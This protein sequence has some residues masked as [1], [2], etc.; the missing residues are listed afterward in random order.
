[1]EDEAEFNK[2]P[3]DDRCVHKVNCSIQKIIGG[4]IVKEARRMVTGP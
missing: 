3:L 2:I 4:V 1:M